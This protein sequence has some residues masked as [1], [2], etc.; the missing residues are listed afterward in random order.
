MKSINNLNSYKKINKA[1]RLILVF[2]ILYSIGIFLTSF[3]VYFSIL[4][5]NSTIVFPNGYCKTYFGDDQPYI[6]FSF[7]MKNTGFIDINNL[8]LG[9]KLHVRYF[10]ITQE[11]YVRKNFFH[12]IQFFGKFKSLETVNYSFNGESK[13]FDHAFLSLFW[14]HLGSLVDITFFISLEFK[15]NH[16]FN[17]LPVRISFADINVLLFKCPNCGI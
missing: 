11:K 15:Y 9:V 8:N 1:D 2:T 7:G 6:N 13:H 12:K 17:T 16:F 10:N 5:T 14:A 3:S 4:N